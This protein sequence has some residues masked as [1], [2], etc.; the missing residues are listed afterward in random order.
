MRD[1]IRPV[2]TRVGEARDISAIGFDATTSVTVHRGVIGIRDDHV[3]RELLDVL[4]DPFTLGRRLNQNP[5]PRSAPKHTPQS[6]A[7]GCNALVDR[8]HRLSDN[9]NLTFLLVEI[10]GTILHGWSPLLRL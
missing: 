10:D 7:S 3:V 6:I 1:A 4:R 8:L 5:Y 2:L 9:P